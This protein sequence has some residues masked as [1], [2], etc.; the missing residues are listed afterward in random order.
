M[1]KDK[2][3]IYQEFKNRLNENSMMPFDEFVNLA[4]YHPTLGYYSQR[5]ER[6]GKS[7]NSDFYTSNSIGSPWG[8]ID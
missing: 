3:N 7:D 6:V 1:P 4:L 8:R 5:K 2:T